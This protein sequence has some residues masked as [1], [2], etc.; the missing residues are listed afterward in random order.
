MVGAHRGDSLKKLEHGW[1]L[2]CREWGH[3][4]AWCILGNGKNLCKGTEVGTTH[5][6]Q[7]TKGQHDWDTQREKGSASG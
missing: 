1:P 7:G 6:L 5:S 2:A 3:Q 4:D